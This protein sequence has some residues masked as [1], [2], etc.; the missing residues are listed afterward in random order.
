MRK[1]EVKPGY[2]EWEIYVNDKLYYS[3]DDQF[4]ADDILA[5]G[6]AD[7]ANPDDISDVTYEGLEEVADMYIVPMQDEIQD[8]IENHSDENDG[9]TFFNLTSEEINELRRQLVQVW[10]QHFGVSEE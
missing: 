3:I 4:L 6:F 8:R 2:Y 5:Y 7:D 9:Y 10:A 1:I